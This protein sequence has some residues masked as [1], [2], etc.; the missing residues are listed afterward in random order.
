MYN[1]CQKTS[2]AHIKNF[3]RFVILG[4]TRRKLKFFS[5]ECLPFFLFS[6]YS[7]FKNLSGLSELTFLIA[8]NLLEYSVERERNKTVMDV[9]ITRYYE[10]ERSKCFFFHWK[11]NFFFESLFLTFTQLLPKGSC[12]LH[13]FNL[14]LFWA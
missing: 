7:V 8:P 12:N 6:K 2:W 9:C 5:L 14:N 1:K 10:E 11:G 3:L 13:N 4:K